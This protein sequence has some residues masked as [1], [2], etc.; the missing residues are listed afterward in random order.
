MHRKVR[1]TMLPAVITF[2]VGIAM[3]VVGSRPGRNTVWGSL[4]VI[5]GG[6]V[7]AA[8]VIIGFFAGV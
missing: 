6:V 8:G 1:A 7:A 4:L 5:L 3:V 2:F